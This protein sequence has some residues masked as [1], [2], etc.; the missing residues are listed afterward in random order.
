MGH[1]D[2]TQSPLEPMPKHPHILKRDG[3]YYYRKR[4]PTDLVQAG[5]YGKKKEIKRALGANNLAKANS[6][7]QTLA[8]EVDADFE[9]KRREVAQSNPCTKR[10]NASG[11]VRKLADLSNLEIRDFVIR[12]FITR[13]KEEAVRR[14][15]DADP[16]I[17][18]DRLATARMD[19]GVMQTAPDCYPETCWN[20]IARKTLADAGIATDGH[21]DKKLRHLAQMIR[22]AAIESAW[23]TEQ[24]I[25]GQPFQS[26][27][28]YF[29]GIFGSTPMPSSAAAGKT[30]GD[31]CVSYREH[32]LQ[33]VA[34][35]RLAQS[36]I[37]KI[38]MRCRILTDLFGG[39]MALASLSG[40][41]ATRLVDFLP[42]MP[43]NATK[44][45]KGISLVAAAERES[46]LLVKRLIHPE[47]AEDYL[48]GLSA[49]LSYGKE[50]GW[51]KENPLKGRLIRE[52]MAKPKK[53][54]RQTL[55]P[56]EMKKVFASHD[57]LSQRL[58]GRKTLEA[59]YWVPLLCLFHGTRS[60]EVAGMHV[61]DVEEADGIAFLNLREHADHRLKNET[62]ARRVPLHQKLVELGFM[63]FVAK[64]RED[65][66]KGHLFTGLTRNRNGSMADGIGKWWHRHVRDVL[67]EPTESE[68]TGTWGLH[69][70]RHSWKAAA[71][72]AGL[73]DSTQKHLG[74]WSQADAADG[75][76]WSGALPMLK[77][78]I[79]KIEFPGVT[80]YTG[81]RIKRERNQTR[82][83]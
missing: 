3:R 67:G 27:D 11:T 50:L 60:N 52:R 75:Y 26:N 45:Y 62:S 41:H 80:F 7:A 31:L 18:A 55:T 35:G 6:L 29:R 36:T 8:L 23:R 81:R 16:D 71:R 33:K 38:D 34:K 73:D 83:N 82:T 64:R 54:N 46:K 4:I 22:N 69:S 59:R 47:T 10:A 65:E 74:G 9:A 79:D 25:D 13:E 39:G 24:A 42:T 12:W 17:R 48:T 21:T 53:Q 57:F 1:N 44:R 51:L 14:S 19:L 63:E 78:S 49:M 37:P 30:V 72:A 56:E 43:Q 5:C 15:Y 76:G 40:E 77:K 70:L 58:G 20:A 32:N 2:G 61:A 66:P 68:T 28:E